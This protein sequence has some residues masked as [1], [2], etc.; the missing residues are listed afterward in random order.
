MGAPVNNLFIVVC[1]LTL[2][3]FHELCELEFDVLANYPLGDNDLNLISTITSKK[4]E[5]II[6]NNITCE[7][8][9]IGKWSGGPWES[10]D[11]TLA[12]LVGLKDNGTFQLEARFRSLCGR[13]PAEI[14]WP[15]RLPSF[16]ALGGQIN[17]GQLSQ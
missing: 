15:N 4:V 10:F 9:N 1:D 11:K 5:K 17:I 7:L 12:N 8:F 16:V 14:D 6:I 13:A 2:S 3:L